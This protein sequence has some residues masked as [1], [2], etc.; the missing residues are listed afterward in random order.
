MPVTQTDKKS[1]TGYT[2]KCIG[3][4]IE[5][6]EV[7]TMCKVKNTECHSYEVCMWVLRIQTHQL[8]GENY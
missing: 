1:W 4:D 6:C 3:C 8:S 7:W 5:G 2:E